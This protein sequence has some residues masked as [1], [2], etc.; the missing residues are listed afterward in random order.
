MDRQHGQ[1]DASSKNVRDLNAQGDTVSHWQMTNDY[2][3]SEIDLAK[4][5]KPRTPAAS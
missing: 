4:E 5:N 2:G 1:M 3:A